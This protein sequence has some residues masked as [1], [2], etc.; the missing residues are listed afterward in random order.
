MA[1]GGLLGAR[2]TREMCEQI[3]ALHVD[4]PPGTP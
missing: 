3:A 4:A 2:E 1:A